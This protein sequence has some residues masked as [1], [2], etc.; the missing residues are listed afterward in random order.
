MEQFDYV[1]V[2]GG[3]AG[4]I[5]AN[6]LSACGRYRVLLLEAGGEP[7]HPWIGIPAGFSKLM[8]NKT[9]NW[10]FQTEPEE[11]THHRSI[12]V[13]RGKGLGGSTIINGMIY[14]RGIPQDFDGWAQ[15]GARGWS[16]AEVEPYFRK[17][18]NFSGAPT[19]QQPG[20]RGTDG[21]M[22][23]CEVR[24][25]FPI[26]DAFIKAGEQAGLPRNPPTTTWVNRKASATTKSY[27]R[28]VG[29]GVLP[30]VIC[31][32]LAGVRI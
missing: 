24:E 9:F 14:V 15:A 11:S 29:G 7:R 16:H 1:I 26:A 28:M 18:E 17:L 32:K 20:Q 19:K 22:H 12:A 10:G 8:T 6:R 31:V 27:R 5:L 21:P 25:R 30:T 4:C 23:I 2:G 13:P 3:A